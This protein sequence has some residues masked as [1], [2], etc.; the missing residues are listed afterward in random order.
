LLLL[1]LLLLLRLQEVSEVVKVEEVPVT[2]P[3]QLSSAGA[4]QHST[5]HHT[6][7]AP[8]GRQAHAR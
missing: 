7:G 5:A 2:A 1:L 4:G 8:Q 6:T 3:E